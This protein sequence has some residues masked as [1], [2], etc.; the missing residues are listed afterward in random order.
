MSL[1]V[2]RLTGE[3]VRSRAGEDPGRAG[4]LVRGHP[5]AAGHGQGEDCPGKQEE[6]GEEGL[7]DTR[8]LSS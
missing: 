3:G 2:S 6:E 4:Q 1:I 8:G 7:P 5:A